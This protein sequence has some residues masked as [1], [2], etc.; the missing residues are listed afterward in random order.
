MTLIEPRVVA[1]AGGLALGTLVFLTRML[2]LFVRRS[3]HVRPFLLACIVGAPFSCSQPF[4]QAVPSVGKGTPLELVVNASAPGP[5]SLALSPD[6]RY[7]AV[8]AANSNSIDFWDL[9]DGRR[10]RSFRGPRDLVSSVAMSQD[11]KQVATGASGIGE[12]EIYVWDSETGRTNARLRVSATSNYGTLPQSAW[13]TSLQFTADGSK[14]IVVGDFNSRT[15]GLARFAKEFARVI[16]ISTGKIV[17]S[18]ETTNITSVYSLDV[19][20]DG[21][22]FAIGFS[23][24]LTRVYDLA[25]NEIR[26]LKSKNSNGQAKRLVF[27]PDGTLLALTNSDYNRKITDLEIWEISSGKL[28]RSMQ[29]DNVGQTVGIAWSPDGVEIATRGRN[30]LQIWNV[31]AGILKTQNPDLDGV[32]SIVRYEPNGS[33]IIT[34]GL[35]L[36]LVDSQS[37]RPIKAFGEH[38]GRLL[39][40][41]DVSSKEAMLMTSPCSV[42]ILNTLTGSTGAHI[43]CWGSAIS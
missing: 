18:L 22:L 4:A 20:P 21:R 40:G 2:R 14:I 33:K 39:Q 6:G 32:S 41:T 36:M 3:S 16:D 5:D 17:R 9:E 42:Y 26:V 7:L 29:A 10:I 27:S 30:G 8:P 25:G 12:T 15:A 31:K 19:S 24:G 11:G 37:A 28:M 38:P 35:T 43:P 1:M 34:S 13:I 23:H